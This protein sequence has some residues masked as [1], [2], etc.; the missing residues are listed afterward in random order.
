MASATRGRPPAP[1][2]T[3]DRPIR[4]LIRRARRGR[5][6]FDDITF[7]DHF[8]GIG[9]NADGAKRLGLRGVIA[10]NHDRKAI[11]THALNHPEIEH[12]WC[13]ISTSDAAAYPTAQILIASPECNRRSRASG[14]KRNH[15]SDDLT[16]L[17]DTSVRSRCTMNDVIK[18]TAI[19][20]YLAVLVENVVEIIHWDD[21]PGLTF[22]DWWKAMLD[23][24]YRGRI[25]SLNAQFTGVPQSRDRAYVVFT[26]LDCAEPD[27]DFHPAAPCET[28]GVDVAAV[29]HFK[30]PKT[31]AGV[32]GARHGQYI[33]RCSRC[34]QPV[35]PYRVPVRG[36]LDLTR[37]SQ[38]IGERATPLK[39]KTMQRCRLAVRMLAERYGAMRLS[40]PGTKPTLAI[41]ARPLPEPP[42]RQDLATMDVPDAIVDLR[43]DP[44]R[45][46]GGNESRT[47]DEPLSTVCAS[48]T[49][50]G[51]LQ[52]AAIAQ[53]GGNLFERPGSRTRIRDVNDPMAATTCTPDRALLQPPAA[54]ISNMTHNAP[55]DV[56]TDAVSTTTT[57]SKH[58]VLQPPAAAIANYGGPSNGWARTADEPI[59][60]ITTT[61]SHSVLQP[62]AATVAYY[63][64][65]LQRDVDEP[66]PTV[67]TVDR[68]GLVQA[69]A[70]ERLATS[71]D[72]AELSDDDIEELVLTSRLRMMQP[73]ELKR[74]HG[75]EASYRLGDWSKRDQVK[76]I[77]NANPPNTIEVILERIVEAI[78]G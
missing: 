62:P 58:Y 14:K 55:R 66:L 73:E 18:W 40:G 67:T 43:G 15:R 10:L 28:C 32:Y 17:T 29:Q 74:A 69:P 49:H 42:A 8:C 5:F 1:A 37:P 78:W 53:I 24:G 60:A 45:T 34:A 63:G 57:G 76:L 35:E 36:V 16:L 13:D 19:H 20:R 77:G 9:G 61:D 46:G 68:H 12:G 6:K 39:P 52:P 54:A 30:N 48:G 3:D 51:L 71:V 75:F 65:F 4:R 56:A 50:H 26:R 64:T 27:L 44:G 33:Y 47:L 72:A 2:R 70:D 11:D 21:G 59:G 25:V 7:H 31:L 38:V 41:S 23:L 22:A